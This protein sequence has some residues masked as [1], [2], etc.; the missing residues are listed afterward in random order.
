M[1][2][3]FE[4]TAPLSYYQQQELVWEVYG[5]PA[6]RQETHWLEWKE[7]LDLGE[8]EVQAKIAKAVLGFANRSPTTAGRHA[9]GCAYLLVGVAPG[10]L[11]GVARVDAAA[12]EDGIGRYLSRKVQ[13]RP[14]YVEIDER[15]VLVIQ[16]E[17][18][19]WGDGLHTVQKSYQGRQFQMSKGDIYVRRQAATGRADDAEVEML[20]ERLARGQSERRPLSVIGEPERHDEF[21]IAVTSVPRLLLL[22]RLDLSVTAQEEFLRAQE[23]VRESRGYARPADDP[24][25]AIGAR[26]AVA[27]GSVRRAQRQSSP[28][29]GNRSELRHRLLPVLVESAM[30]RDIGGL[31]LTLENSSDMTF[32]NV[33]LELTVPAGCGIFERRDVLSMLPQSPRRDQQTRLFRAAAADHEQRVPLR[34]VP[35]NTGRRQSRSQPEKFTFEP[36][37]VRAG[38]SVPLP[39]VYIVA[40]ASIEPGLY[41]LEWSATATNAPKRV[42]G[43]LRMVVADPVWT[44]QALLAA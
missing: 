22:D 33:E 30:A 14:D 18:P 12:L 36:V 11:D 20:S 25:L 44:P 9:G 6:C 4:A 8:K 27:G 2:R 13:W 42:N 40:V 3:V 15:E 41:P 31:T 10:S 16:V 24:G 38:R 5:S 23:P 26:G 21:R 17:A 1:S 29:G 19:N 35:G 37:T 28:D 7:T 32:A 34:R 43:G 39:K